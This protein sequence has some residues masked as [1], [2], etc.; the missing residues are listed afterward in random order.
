MLCKL[1]GKDVGHIGHRLGQSH[2]DKKY[3]IKIIMINSL[4]LMQIKSRIYIMAR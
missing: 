3:P 1:C 4:K 2:K